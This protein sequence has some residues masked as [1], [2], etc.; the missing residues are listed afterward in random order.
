MTPANKTG[1]PGRRRP[2]FS[3]QSTMSKSRGGRRA[4]TLRNGEHPAPRRKQ[5]DH[6]MMSARYDST[7]GNGNQVPAG[8]NAT[9]SRP[10]KLGV[11]MDRTP[12][13]QPP[14]DG[15][16]PRTG[17]TSSGAGSPFR[18]SGPRAQPR[19]N[20]GADA[21]PGLFTPSR[22]VIAP[23]RDGSRAPPV[24][25]PPAGNSS[26]CHILPIGIGCAFRLSPVAPHIMSFGRTAMARGDEGV[27]VG[28]DLDGL[29]A[30]SGIFTRPRRRTSP[31]AR[32]RR[33]R[34]ATYPRTRS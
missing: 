31:R 26:R 27:Q 1:A 16:G 32:P 24:I 12:R 4:R 10:A 22:G 13:C 21:C 19:V 23:G 15:A 6:P 11:Y 9:A 5:A 30:R 33:R 17:A 29:S 8:K 14:S 25:R 18:G 34:W 28:A 7:L 2:R 3:F 20:S